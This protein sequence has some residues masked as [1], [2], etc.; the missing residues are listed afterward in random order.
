MRSKSLRC[1]SVRDARLVR[2]L[3]NRCHCNACPSIPDGAGPARADY[4]SLD[5]RR[6]RFTPGRGVRAPNQRIRATDGTA[7]SRDQALDA[8][9]AT[10]LL[11]GPSRTAPRPTESSKVGG[12][13]RRGPRGDR[14]V[15]GRTPIRNASAGGSIVGSFT[16]ASWTPLLTGFLPG[17][18]SSATGP[19]T[20]PHRS[21][22]RFPRPLRGRGCPKGG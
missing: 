8:P 2:P 16:W 19:S 13:P 22:P 6:V 17:V 18:R 21:R 14:A 20:K 11:A 12:V 5:A 1:I 4:R 15:G 3:G 7:S 9:I 10:G